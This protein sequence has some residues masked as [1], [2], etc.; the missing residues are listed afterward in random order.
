[1]KYLINILNREYRLQKKDLMNFKDFFKLDFNEDNDGN[2]YPDS[3]SMSDEI[4][5]EDKKKKKKKKS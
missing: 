2:L 3:T 5:S 4:W 1:V